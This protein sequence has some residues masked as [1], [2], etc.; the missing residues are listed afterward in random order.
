MTIRKEFAGFIMER[1]R[2]SA[3]DIPGFTPG[4]ASVRL[5]TDA[6]ASE[7]KIAAYKHLEK[8]CKEAGI[9]VSAL[10]SV[11]PEAFDREKQVQI[12][13]RAFVDGVPDE[14]EDDPALAFSSANNVRELDTATVDALHEI[15]LA[16][17]TMKIVKPEFDSAA[18]DDLLAGLRDPGSEALLAP[19]DAQTLRMILT[20]IARRE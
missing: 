20:A 3:V 9:A 15:Y 19:L 11:D 2:C 18:L 5:L 14:D 1:L 6:Q 7:A 4:S 12:V 10:D 8:R 17:Q 13:Y 16:Y